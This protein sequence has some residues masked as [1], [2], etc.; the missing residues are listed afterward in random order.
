MALKRACLLPSP[1]CRPQEG[2]L[3]HTP[4]AY[5]WPGVEME[6]GAGW[7][8]G[9]QSWCTG[10]RGGH[11]LQ[12]QPWAGPQRSQYF[13]GCPPSA[14][15]PGGHTAPGPFQALPPQSVWLSLCLD[16]WPRC[17]RPSQAL[18]HG[19]DPVTPEAE[20]TAGHWLDWLLT[21][22]G[23]KGR[24][25]QGRRFHLNQPCTP[26]RVIIHLGNQRGAE[27][28]GYC[29]AAGKKRWFSSFGGV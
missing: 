23:V 8:S 28:S 11:C 16:R 13:M 20:E 19:D 21:L 17:P 7:G 22:S 26:A 10:M 18:I 4:S 1:A 14:P 6:V 12:L 5:S 27:A 2:S 29:T 25:L 24:D 15:W 9:M 3:P